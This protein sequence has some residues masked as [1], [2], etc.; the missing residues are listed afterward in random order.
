MRSYEAIP[1]GIRT[2]VGALPASL[3][4]RSGSIF[5]SGKE[6]F[7]AKSDLYVLGLNPGGSPTQASSATIEAYLGRFRE[8]EKPWC[9]YS[10]ECWEGAAPGTW[11]LQPRILHM[12]REL[13]LD[14][15]MVP[16]SNVVFVQSRG[17][18]ELESEKAELLGAC[19][20]VHQAVI[21]N[22]SI[23]TVLCFGATAGAWVRDRLSAFELIDS[24]T[25]SNRRGWTSRN[26]CNAD[27][28]QV[29]T[30]THPSRADW[31]NPL[32]DPT[33]LVMRAIAR[34][35]ERGSST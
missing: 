6:A 34:G 11:G 16:A 12:L 32:A 21:D 25:E 4:G 18:R 9:E 22:L 1:A 28:R 8:L 19:W 26:H 13:N 23:S 14:P 2:A 15:R 31:R 29:V 5:Y 3:L 30:L 35:K 33:P 20:A 7:T 24:F 10:D 17:E 27:G